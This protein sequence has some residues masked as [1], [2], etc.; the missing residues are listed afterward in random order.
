[1][2]QWKGWLAAGA[3][4]AHRESPQGGEE[5]ERE[6]SR[7]RPEVM[8]GARGNL[9]LTVHF[10]RSKAGWGEAGGCVNWGEGKRVKLDPV[11][12]LYV[13]FGHTLLSLCRQGV[14]RKSSV[15]RG[16]I[17]ASK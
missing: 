12:W 6:E 4:T 14:G 13:F 17:L 5:T 11:A 7:R 10:P 16:G 8:M 1:M 2:Q 9:P 3:Q 15:S